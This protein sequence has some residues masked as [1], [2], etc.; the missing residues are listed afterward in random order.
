MSEY[1]CVS[2]DCSIC[3]VNR[4]QCE[5]SYC[6]DYL[7]KMSKWKTVVPK[8]G[9]GNGEA[10]LGGRKMCWWHMWDRKILRMFYVWTAE[11][12]LLSHCD[13]TELILPFFQMILPA[14]FWFCF[15]TSPCTSR[16]LLTQSLPY[17]VT[18]LCEF[19]INF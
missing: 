3:C 14:I 15:L 4:L 9:D 18:Q 6:E 16:F 13:L 8:G 19:N 1:N 10:H 17:F 11:W 5:D 2:Q 12:H 7:L